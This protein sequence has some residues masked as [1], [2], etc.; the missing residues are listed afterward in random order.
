MDICRA[1]SSSSRTRLRTTLRSSSC[2]ITQDIL[3][4]LIRTHLSGRHLELVGVRIWLTIHLRIRAATITTA[5]PRCKIWVRD[6]PCPETVRRHTAYLPQAARTL[7]TSFGPTSRRSKLGTSLRGSNSSVHLKHSCW[8][9]KQGRTSCP[10]VLG[11]SRSRCRR[12]WRMDNSISPRYSKKDPAYKWYVYFCFR[13]PVRCSPLI[14][15]SRSVYICDV[16]LGD[17]MPC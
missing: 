10:G 14:R 8:P 3:R 2:R 4:S 15:M 11:S 5:N 9:G 6:R 7:K 12:V 16:Y 1:S 13:R 17:G